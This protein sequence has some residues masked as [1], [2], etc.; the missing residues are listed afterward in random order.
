MEKAGL[1]MQMNDST[2][3]IH[4]QARIL[5]TIDFENRCVVGEKENSAHGN[6]AIFLLGWVVQLQH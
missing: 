4:K 6:T 1:G 3:H 2:R 5:T